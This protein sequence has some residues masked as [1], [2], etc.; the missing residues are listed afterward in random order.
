[1][2]K[3]N[4]VLI[5][6]DQMRADCLGAAGHPDVETPFLDTMANHGIRFTRAY[7]ATPTCIPA[8]AALFTGLSQRSHKRV[9]YQDGVAWDYPVT[10]PGEFAATGYHTHCSGKMHVWPPRSLMGFHSVDLH[11]GFLSHRN[12][13]TE[14]RYWWNR[15]D[16]YLHDLQRER[17]PDADIGLDGIDCNSWVAKPYTMPEHLHPTNWTTQKS[18]DFLRRCDPTRPF[19][20]WTSYVAPHPPFTPPACYY[21]HYARKEMRPPS[22][23]DWAADCGRAYPDVDAFEGCLRPAAVS[24][25]QAGYYGLITHLDHQIGRLLRALKDEGVLNRT[26]ILFTSDHGEMLGDH[27]MFRKSQPFNGSVH[28]PF[29]ICDP[30]RLLPVRH[31]SE[32]DSLA[33]LRD[34]M[35]TL[36][37][38]A[39]V[40]VPEQTEGLDLLGELRENRERE[41]LHGEHLAQDRPC[42]AQY[43]VTRNRKYIWYSDCG[44]ELLFD[45]AA[46]PGEL[47]NISDEAGYAGDL[48]AL[49]GILAAE[50]AG[51]EEGY[52]DG[53]SLITG[54]RPVAVLS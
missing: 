17:G 16:D 20:L 10:M 14:V 35:P 45:L 2:E 12:T 53:A 30:G 6:A 1:M 41:Y 22:V 31:G 33:E 28:I 7:S 19:F 40:A 38:A 48:S 50:L 8:R 44:R 36:L 39:G 29:L 18:I 24:S 43:I 52:S 34:V 51:R 5:T 46:D 37:A 26:I 25:M 13:G 54:R 47:C 42:S 27:H 15:V 11:D 23:G 21:D 49:R 3:P 4:I 9:G 32:C